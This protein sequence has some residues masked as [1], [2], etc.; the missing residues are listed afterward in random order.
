MQAQNDFIEIVIAKLRMGLTEPRPG[1][2]IIRHQFDRVAV[3]VVVQTE[4]ERMNVVVVDLVGLEWEVLWPRTG[5]TL[6]KSN[7]VRH[8]P[9]RETEF[10]MR[11]CVFFK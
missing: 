2:N 3:N 8:I 9:A 4:R 6:H 11:I 5:W 7:A 1:M 10:R